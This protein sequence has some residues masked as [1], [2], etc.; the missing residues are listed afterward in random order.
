MATRRHRLVI[1]PNIRPVAAKTGG[2]TT[3]KPKPSSANVAV[4]P[5]SPAA[6]TQLATPSVEENSQ[7]SADE[8]EKKVE[9][10]SDAD[11][12]QASLKPAVDITDDDVQPGATSGDV[13]SEQKAS[14][15]AKEAR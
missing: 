10:L 11:L 9:N 7:Q 14:S 2:A 1:K 5:P 6:R 12:C 13:E 3:P 15:T 4:E 8:E